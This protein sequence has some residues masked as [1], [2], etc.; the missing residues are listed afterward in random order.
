MYY[1]TWIKRVQRRHD[2][3][4]RLTHLTRA[5]GDECA[6]YVLNKILK[7]KCIY[8][9]TTDTGYIVGPDSAVCFQD[10]PLL[11]IAENIIYE[12]KLCRETGRIN[13]RYEPFGIRVNKQHAFRRG[14]REV[15][16][17]KTYELKSILPETEWWR[18]VNHNLDDINKI[19]DWTH[20]REWRIKGNYTF[21][22]TDIDVIVKDS[23]YYKKFIE[24]WMNED[25]SILTMINGI[26]C[27]DSVIK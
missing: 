22:F 20:E 26:N 17:G 11:G 14:A 13:K 12:N 27:L 18:I 8:G 6:F 10:I 4:T 9:S 24:Y 7:E 1:D 3:T 19:I 15:I 25:P 2:I 21:E 23:N 16:Y 5:N